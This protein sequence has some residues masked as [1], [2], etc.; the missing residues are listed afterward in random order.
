MTAKALP[1]N[2][3][4]TMANGWSPIIGWRD[5][6]LWW[7]EEQLRGAACPHFLQDLPKGVIAYSSTHRPANKSGPIALRDVR[8]LW[9]QL[10]VS[11]PSSTE[12]FLWIA[13]GREVKKH[14]DKVP[15]IRVVPSWRHN[16]AIPQEDVCASQSQL[17][18]WLGYP[19]NEATKHY[20]ARAIRTKSA[21]SLAASFLKLYKALGQLLRVRRRAY[22]K[23]NKIPQAVLRVLKHLTEW[24]HST[25]KTPFCDYTDTQKEQVIE[26]LRA[27]RKRIAQQQA[28]ITVRP[29]F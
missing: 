24:T 29:V 23:E 28:V 17:L 7:S 10:H 12:P 18:F 3:V 16:F 9:R 8:Q 21:A 15:G 13:S 6:N 1:G 4:G 26:R 2:P 5:G 19:M 11:L 22:D 20:S 14:C 27:N 25:N